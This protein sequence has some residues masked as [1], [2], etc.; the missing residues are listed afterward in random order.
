MPVRTGCYGDGHISWPGHTTG[1]L[2]PS[3]ITIGEAFLDV[4]YETGMV[5]KWH[6]GINAHN[7]TDGEHLPHNHGF[8]Y[9]GT[10]L[11]LSNAWACDEEQWHLSKPN[12]L[13]CFLYKNATM[14]QQPYS[15]Y[16]LS[17]TF[18]NDSIG[19][20]RGSVKEKKKP[21]FLY[22]GIAQ[23][24]VDMYCN[25][26]FRGSSKRG[27]YGDNIREMAWTVAAI[28]EEV[29][30][31]KEENNTLAIFT[32]DHGPGIGLCNEGGDAGM[33]KGGKLNF[34]EG[35]IRVP[36]IFRWPGKIRPASTSDVVASHMD[37]FPTL[38]K[39][40]GG[41]VP[42]DRIMD[43]KDIS[44]VL[45]K[46]SPEP[47]PEP[48]DTPQNRNPLDNEPRL[49][50]WYCNDKL[51]AVR[52]GSHKFH[53]R[54][55]KVQTKEE[56]HA[57]PGRCGDGGFP[58]QQNFP[59]GLNCGTASP[60]CLSQHDPPL[61]YNLGI[62]PGEAYPLDVSFPKHE[63]VFTEMML[64]LETFLATLIMPPPL[65]GPRSFEDSAGVWPCC[66]NGTFPNCG[67]NYQYEGPVPKP[68]SVSQP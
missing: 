57:E 33:L 47:Q 65:L 64:E 8:D 41:S 24:H 20:M 40:V 30:N 17:E 59:C 44:S 1:C 15:H 13:L 19:F 6:L 3:E 35:G 63:A 60:E 38:M 46:Q 55:I 16:K 9:V 54:S 12:P 10:N 37:I 23:P 42:D 49:L 66:G 27:R 58:F 2:N 36:A 4:G 11:P 5:G 22:Y 31:L 48:A 45:F 32:S 18:V 39:I 51:Y 56:H 52:Y 7:R 28:L 43:G 14:Y 62:D 25:H 21:F 29:K 61:M 26:G 34:W 67:C 68:G 50:V 53:F